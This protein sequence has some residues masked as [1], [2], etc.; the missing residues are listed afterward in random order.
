MAVILKEHS[1][2]CWAENNL[3]T[4]WAKQERDNGD[5]SN[6]RS[7]WDQGGS[8]KER[9]KQIKLGYVGKSSS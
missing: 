3:G 6:N 5:T 9:E 1:G 4:T 2:R 7:S 8:S